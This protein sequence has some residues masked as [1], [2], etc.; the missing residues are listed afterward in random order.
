MR[1]LAIALKSLPIDVIIV[2][3]GS[4]ES[5]IWDELGHTADDNGLI[6]VVQ[7]EI[8]LTADGTHYILL[9][10]NHVRLQPDD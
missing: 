3:E 2:S 7:A 4:E 9:K 1:S 8:R 5:R 6:V 10:G